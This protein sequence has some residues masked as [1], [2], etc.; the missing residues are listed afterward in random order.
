MEAAGLSYAEFMGT[1]GARP[2]GQ[3]LIG[4]LDSRGESLLADN[5][6][7]GETVVA[8]AQGDFGQALVLTDRRLYVVKWGFQAG[9]T[10]GGKCTGFDY[11]HLTSI[12]IKKHA[13]TRMVVVNSASNQN[14]NKLSYWGDRKDGNNAIA[15]D[16][17]VTFSAKDDGLFQ[18]MVN[19]GRESIM[20][21]QRPATAGP[22]AAA[23]SPETRLEKLAGLLDRGLLTDAEFVAQ[24]ARI[25]SEM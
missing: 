10:F 2:D 4:A 22:S 6:S 9:Q 21:S 25:L 12:E 20:E 23:D 24:K 7:D 16:N 5:L 3:D 17:V 11:R 18:Q 8:K 19:M 13:V 14:N 1:S 15:A